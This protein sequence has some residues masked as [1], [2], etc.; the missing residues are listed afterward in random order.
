MTILRP[1]ET[2]QSVTIIP[3][4]DVTTISVNLRNES[5][6]TG[7]TFENVDTTYGN[8]YMTFEINKEVSEGENYEIELIDNETIL[9]R[10]KCFA[11]DETDLENYKINK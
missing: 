10:G 9:F 2:T 8:G 5:K 3:R 6:A 11:T 1:S 7:E 4:Y